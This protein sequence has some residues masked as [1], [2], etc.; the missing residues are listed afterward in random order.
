MSLVNISGNRFASCSFDKTIKIWSFNN[1]DYECCQTL[2]DHIC[3]VFTLL[4]IEKD[5]HL[6]SGAFD[7]TSKVWDL[8]NYQCIL[9]IN[10]DFVKENLLLPNGYFVSASNHMKLN[11]FHLNNFECVN[12]IGLTGNTES[13]LLLNDGRFVSG[14]YNR[15]ITIYNY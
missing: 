15:L 4:Y 2:I 8:E 6:L 3:W 11:I 5:N 12:S 9:S 1:N 14:K 7:G 13:L 10:T